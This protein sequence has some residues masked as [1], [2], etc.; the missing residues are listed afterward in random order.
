MK[1]IKHL[2]RH[3]VFIVALLVPFVAVADGS[4]STTID[5]LNYT[6]YYLGD[7]ES[8]VAEYV[9]VCIPDD[10]S[11]AAIIAPSV[12]VIYSWRVQV[13]YENGSPIYET[14]SKNLKGKVTTIYGIYGSGSSQH[15]NLTSVSI[16]NTVT[17][18]G[19][20]AFRKSAITSIIIPNSVT[21]IGDLAFASCRNLTNIDIPNSVISI[22][23]QAFNCCESLTELTIPNSVTIIGNNAFNSCNRIRTVTIPNS[24]E[25]INSSAFKGC[26]SI[27]K[28]YINDL[29]KWCRIKFGDADS[30]PA[31][32]S[33]RLFLNNKE[34]ID[35]LIPNTV[36][37]ISNFA[38][39]NCTGLKSVT[40]SP[41][42]TN[43]GYRAFYKCTSL[44]NA[45]LG[46][47]VSIVDNPG[48]IGEDAF[49]ECTG[50]T[51]LT[52]GNSF[53]TIGNGAFC[54]CS[55]LASLIIPNSVTVIGPDKYWYNYT[56][57]NGAFAGCI[58]LTSVKIPSSVTRFGK[59]AFGGC[60][61]LK[62][63]DISDLEAWCKIKYDSYGG[64][65]NPCYYAHKL[66]LNGEEIIDLVIPNTVKT[67]NDLA[68]AGCDFKSVTI[69][70]LVTEIG[71]RAFCQSTL[72]TLTLGN[73]VN[74]IKKGAF[75]YCST[76]NTIYSKSK[77]APSMSASDCFLNAY[78]ATVYVPIGA[79]R[80]YELTN[81]W[82]LFPNIVEMDMN[83]TP[84][85]D[86]NGDGA[87]NIADVN[88][89]INAILSNGSSDEFDINNDG[90]VNIGDINAIINI[91]LKQ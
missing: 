65:S 30:N 36:T 18:I 51:N 42:V 70:N 5:G 64:A 90:A 27:N 19:D 78:N 89:V 37:S 28:V 75:E 73:S 25:E 80:D 45:C 33:H 23:A 63:V 21:I 69:S 81:Y 52:I 12:T 13:G 17:T 61:N 41:S 71:I 59:N 85:G 67:I 55:C 74:Y 60:N 35:L 56:M 1:D 24:I 6:L 66:Y 22:G 91:I 50:L 40:I 16:P 76:L 57:A 44:T 79:K 54:S 26:S 84:H 32:F 83:E 11:G 15:P 2:L 38:F 47:T 86:T 9:S 88:A 29:D 10:F 62:R 4:C 87:V 31:S 58:G 72:T 8:A 43:I 77:V 34:L 68:F 46:D 48:E 20:Y 14:R 82:N 7:H 53:S 49:M 39:N 3:S